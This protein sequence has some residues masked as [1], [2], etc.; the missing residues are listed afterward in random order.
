MIDTDD[1]SNWEHTKKTSAYH[2]D[3]NVIDARWDLLQGVGR[4]EGNWSA[5]LAESIKSAEPVTWRTRLRGKHAKESSMIAQEEYDLINAGA[6]PNLILLRMQHNVPDI[7]KKMADITG[8]DNPKV[9]VHVQYP[10]EVFTAHIDKLTPYVTSVT[11]TDKVIRFIVFLTDWMPGHFYQFGNQNVQ[12]WRAGD[13]HTF[14]W[15]HVPHCTANA[16][17]TP[18]V[19]LQVTG[20]STIKTKA[21]LETAANVSSIKI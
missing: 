16:G 20:Q 18:R 17:H 4:F 15:K 12:G 14:A 8:V 5:E 19:T 2:F 7:F 9:R 21:F 10:G 1:I 3:N 6:D 11:D 13:I